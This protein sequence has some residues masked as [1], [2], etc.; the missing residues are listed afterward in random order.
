M[1][2]QAGRFNLLN[3]AVE[4]RHSFELEAEVAATLRSAQG[5]RILVACSGGADS[6]FLLCLLASYSRAFGLELIVAHYNHCWRGNDSDA[7]AEFV[8][9]LAQQFS[10]LC[11]VGVRPQDQPAF[12]ETSARELRLDFLRHA[13]REQKCNFIAF[14]HQLDDILETQLQ[15]IARG[16]GSEGLAAPKPVAR[17]EQHPIHIRPLLHVGARDLRLALATCGAAWCE[18]ASNSDVSIARNALRHKVIPELIESLD[19]DPAVGA[20]RS[21]Y[22]LAE[23]AAALDQLARQQMAAAYAGDPRLDRAEPR[24]L[25]NALLRRALSA[26]LN[27]HQLIKS[28]GASAMDLLLRAICAAQ[29]QYRMSAG[30]AYIM[31]DSQ[32]LWLERTDASSAPFYFEPILLKP[33]ATVVLPSGSKLKIEQ[34]YLDDLTCGQILRGEVDCLRSAYIVS[35]E[36]SYYKIRSCQPGDRFTPIGAPGSKKLKDWFID[37]KIPHRERKQLPVVTTQAG[38]VIWVPGFAPANSRKISLNTNSALRLTYQM[39]HSP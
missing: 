36:S 6:V 34:V 17:F 13:A 37:R 8:A 30:D 10:F 29:A 27:R 2:Q 19:R 9:V 31:L 32:Q 12:T 11:V 25:P 16:C 15:R 7:D 26:W 22:L 5:S 14:G 24:Q 38:E 33:D 39:S 23:D 18:D 20:A 3:F 35:H 4:L 1:T 28:V 21:R